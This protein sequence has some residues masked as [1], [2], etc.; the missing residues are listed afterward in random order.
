MPKRALITGIT[1]NLEV[2]PALLN[3]RTPGQFS[4]EEATAGVEQAICLDS[5]TLE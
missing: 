3:D 1:Y 4:G 2:S 5:L